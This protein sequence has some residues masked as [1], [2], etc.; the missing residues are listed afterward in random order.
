MKI[1]RPGNSTIIIGKRITFGALV[2]GV[3]SCG[4]WLWNVTHPGSPIP[5]EIAISLTTVIT[6]IG[7]VVIVNK[8]GI[9]Q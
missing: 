8:Y 9:T 1:E 2:G 3:V 7:Q 4:V 6:A 5:G